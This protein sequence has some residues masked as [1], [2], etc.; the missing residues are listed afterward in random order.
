MN[1]IRAPLLPPLVVERRWS[2]S[3]GEEKP[4]KGTDRGEIVGDASA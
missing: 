3:T 1:S 4:R 2:K